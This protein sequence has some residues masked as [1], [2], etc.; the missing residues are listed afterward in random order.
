MT[1]R[2]AFRTTAGLALAASAAPA[3]PAAGRLKQSAAR[4]CYN[5]VQLDDLCREGAALG[6]SGIDLVQPPDWPTIQ[7]HGL[8]PAVTSG[9]GSIP[10]A[11]NQTENHERLEAEMKKNILA[12]EAAKVPNVITFSGNRKGM[13]DDVGKAN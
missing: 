7:K 5:K 9:A 8:T 12:A 11:W 6:L 4:W 3:A 1:R 13:S 2:S 10:N